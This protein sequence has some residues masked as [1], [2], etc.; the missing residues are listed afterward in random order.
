MASGLMILIPIPLISLIVTITKLLVGGP[1]ITNKFIYVS[2]ESVSTE[3][4]W[5]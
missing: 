3:N 4:T 1:V 2:C 5:A